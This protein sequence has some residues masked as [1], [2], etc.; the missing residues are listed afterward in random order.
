MPHETASPGLGSV[1]PAF[2]WHGK[3]VPPDVGNQPS[4]PSALQTTMPPMLTCVGQS[5][6]QDLPGGRSARYYSFFQEPGILAAGSH[7]FAKLGSLQ[8]LGPKGTDSQH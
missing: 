2:V 3:L 5:V 4:S 8:L 7:S 1:Q 6:A